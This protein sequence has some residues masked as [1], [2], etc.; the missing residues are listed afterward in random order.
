L[1]TIET[2]FGPP[3]D[4]NTIIIAILFVEPFLVIA[5]NVI[6]ARHKAPEPTRSNW[7][8][9]NLTPLEIAYFLRKN[10]IIPK[11]EE[12]ARVAQVTL[13]DIWAKGGARFEG[14]DNRE[15]A[16]EVPHEVLD[17]ATLKVWTFITPGKTAQDLYQEQRWNLVYVWNGARQSLLEKGLLWRNTRAISYYKWVILLILGLDVVFIPLGFISRRDGP[18]GMFYGFSIMLVLL[19]WVF[20]A[21]AYG[22][23]V[24][25]QSTGDGK[26]FRENL[27]MLLRSFAA[28]VG[29]RLIQQCIKAAKLPELQRNFG[30]LFLYLECLPDKTTVKQ[31]IEGVNRKS[32]EETGT[33]CLSQDDMFHLKAIV[34]NFAFDVKCLTK[35]RGPV[36]LFGNSIKGA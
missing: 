1:S 6:A 16:Q 11:L 20:S 14:K 3:N 29:E 12:M 26:R 10:T 18:V 19:F 35:P 4:A 7:Q 31:W 23:S 25:Y 32:M 36:D 33:S 15:L 24:E 21:I 22:G 9:E 8:L 2:Q 28:G 5:V 30:Y 13:A 34:E 27:P 17:P